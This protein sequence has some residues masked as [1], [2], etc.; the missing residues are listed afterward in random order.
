MDHPAEIFSTPVT[1]SI[2]T[3]R[4]MKATVPNKTLVAPAA[5]V[6]I[7]SDI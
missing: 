2:P 3:I 6:S 7:A 1:P 5:V 4:Q